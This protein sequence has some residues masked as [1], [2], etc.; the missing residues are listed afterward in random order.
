MK[1]E[2][3]FPV[4]SVRLIAEEHP[5][6][7]DEYGIVSA[8]SQR[9]VIEAPASH[10]L[11]VPPQ[12]GKDILL[13]SKLTEAIYRLRGRVERVF[14]GNIITVEIIPTAP[15]QRI[16]RRHDFR[17]VETLPFTLR[18]D[19]DGQPKVFELQTL[20]ISAGGVRALLPV[21][22]EPGATGQFEAEFPEDKFTLKCVARVA[23][24]TAAED[25]FD[26]GL[27]FVDLLPGDHDRI[28]NVLMRLLR[29]QVRI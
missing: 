17:V 6:D 10:L 12:V 7:G 13:E 1:F 9:V 21:P 2:R 28:A 18:I 5:H 3:A 27:N 26:T 25:R 16:Q 8:S 11:D 4:R 22:L 15:P 14:F 23:R 24:R 19:I 20:D 29:K